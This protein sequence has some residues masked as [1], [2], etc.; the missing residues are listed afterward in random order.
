MDDTASIWGT[1]STKSKDKK[2]KKGLISEVKDDPVPAKDTKAADIASLDLGDD[3]GSGWNDTAS[4]KGGKKSKRNSMTSSKGDE[5]LNPPAVPDVPDLPV[6]DDWAAGLTP[7]EK[8]KK[9][10]ER[11]KERLAKEKEDAEKKEA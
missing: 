7:K 1:S 8:R 11:E 6:D 4:K 10:K 3:W 5:P 9:E 2:G